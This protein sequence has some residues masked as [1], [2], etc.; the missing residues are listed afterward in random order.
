ML[1]DILIHGESQEEHDYRLTAVLKRLSEAGLTLSKE[2]CQFSTKRVKFL[3]QLVDEEGLK[4][5]PEKVAAI[6]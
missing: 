2:K 4:P 1:D 6:R 5:D 3:G